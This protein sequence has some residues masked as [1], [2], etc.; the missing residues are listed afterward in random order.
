MKKGL[1]LMTFLVAFVL[2][3]ECSPIEALADDSHILTSEELTAAWALAGLDEN[4]APYHEGMEFSASMNASQMQ[5]WLDELLDNEVAAVKQIQ[6][7]MEN[8]LADMKREDPEQY[9]LLTQ[10]SN[11]GS[12]QAMMQTYRDAEALRQLLRYYSDK[13]DTKIGIIGQMK[14][15]LTTEGYTRSQQLSA[16]REIEDAVAAIREIRSE[17]AEN[18]GDWLRSVEEWNMAFQGTAANSANAKRSGNA[19]ALDGWIADVRA[20]QQPKEVRTSVSASVLYP[21][22]SKQSVMGRLNLV[23]S[24]LADSSQTVDVTVKN[25][26]DFNITLY[27]ANKNPLPNATATVSTVD[28]EF[29]SRTD[30][31]GSKGLV[32][33]KSN[34]FHPDSDKN[35]TLNVEVSCDGFTPYLGKG[36]IFEK[37]EEMKI[38]LDVDP[39]KPAIKSA[40]FNGDHKHFRDI[41]KNSYDTFFSSLND[42][43]FDFEVITTAPAWVRLDVTDANGKNIY[44]NA[45]TG[46][47][48]TV[49]F[50][51]TWKSCIKPGTKVTVTVSDNRA[52]TNGIK[53]ELML[54]VYQGVVSA[55]VQDFMGIFD[56]FSGGG[57]TIKAPSGIP[58]LSNMTLNVTIPWEDLLGKKFP[59]I[60]RML[61][62]LDG[63]Y[64]FYISGVGNPF[65]DVVD[66]WKSK[67][68]K[69]LNTAMHNIENQTITKIDMI[70]NMIYPSGAAKINVA[71]M[72]DCELTFGG[73]FCLVA[74]YKTDRGWK[75]DMDTYQANVRI[76][77]GVILTFSMQF[78]WYVIPTPLISLF[79]GIDLSVVVGLTLDILK[80]RSNGVTQSQVLSQTS[81][82]TVTL[83]LQ[84]TFGVNLD[85]GVCSVTL[86]GY[87]YIR[88]VINFPFSSNFNNISFAAYAGM[89]IFLEVHV[90]F[91]KF[92]ASYNFADTKKLKMVN[93][94]WEIYNSR[95]TLSRDSLPWF[96]GLLSI[97][98][99]AEEERETDELSKSRAVEDYSALVPQAQPVLEN[100]TIEGTDIRY[101]D[102]NGQ[103]YAF[104]ISAAQDGGKSRL[105]WV[106]MVTGKSGTFDDFLTGQDGEHYPSLSDYAFDVQ[107]VPLPKEWIDNADVSYKDG[108]NREFYQDKDMVAVSLLC[109]S[110]FHTETAE[111]DGK[112]Q[113][114]QAPNDS[115]A[116][117]F[118]CLHG[119]GDDSFIFVLPG[120]YTSAEKPQWTIYQMNTLDWTAR[121]TQLS[122]VP[123]DEAFTMSYPSGA[124][125]W[126]KNISGGLYISAL[127]DDA[128]SQDSIAEH[129]VIYDIQA[130]YYLQEFTILGQSYPAYNL[131][132][133]Q[134]DQSS[135]SLDAAA[136]GIQARQIGLHDKKSKD[137]MDA[138]SYKTYYLLTT[139]GAAAGNWRL[140]RRDNNTVHAVLDEGD[141]AFYDVLWDRNDRKKAEVFYL[142]REIQQRNKSD[143]DAEVATWHLKTVEETFGTRTQFGYPSLT[144]KRTNL[145]VTVPTDSFSL[146][147]L[148]ESVYIYWLELA[149]GDK[150][151]DQTTYRLRGVIFDPS[152]RVATDDF[153]LAQFTTANK[154]D[155]PVDMF[156]SADGMA[157]YTVKQ[158]GAARNGDTSQATVYAY[159]HGLKPHADLR[160][161]S[162]AESTVYAGTDVDAYVTISNDGSANINTIDLEVV[163][164]DEQGNVIQQGGKDVILETLHVNLLNP[165]ENS[166]KVLL[167]G[168]ASTTSGEGAIYRVEELPGESVQDRFNVEEVKTYWADYVEKND[169]YTVGDPVVTSLESKLLLPGQIAGFKTAVHI[170]ADWGGEVFLAV[171]LAKSQNNALGGYGE[172]KERMDQSEH[173]I[174]VTHRIYAGPQGEPYLHLTI[175]DHAENGEQLR[176]YAEMYLDDDHTPV[177]V[178]LPY[179]PE[180]TSTG[181]THNLDMPLSALLNG[182]RANV[183]NMTVRAVGADDRLASNNDITIYV[184]ASYRDTVRISLQPT[185]QTVLEGDTA[186][187]YVKAAGGREPY[188]YQWQE[189]MG[190]GLGWRNISE[191]TEDT[192]TV[193]D[194][195]LS[196]NGKQ[197]RCV[198]TDYGMEQVTSDSAV[199]NV[200]SALPPTGDHTNLPLYLSLAAAAL[201]LAAALRYAR[202]KREQRRE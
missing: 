25:K 4:A 33:F 148:N 116:Y 17:M 32:V 42:E 114:Y 107:A 128:P 166:R 139:D 153:V 140:V 164:E 55:P 14:N 186:L 36:L 39:G 80:E 122:L 48:C 123:Q 162:L 92:K 29:V 121:N 40:S 95:N 59:V 189:N 62:N 137:D 201:L 143:D 84:I 86:G 72:F 117:L 199:L 51:Y 85:F 185:D 111:T 37:G 57:F 6:S 144:L 135:S 63:S 126:K 12:Y 156:L 110:G 101:V 193:A 69:D 105:T 54:N 45:E 74:R 97:A 11:D 94:E 49:N 145:D 76:Q 178:D 43:S 27:D 96:A 5:K 147:Y 38:Y 171:R 132:F 113:E 169:Q 83:R 180:H 65:K 194:V 13:L 133:A 184:P 102:I 73:F 157:Y 20:W 2:L 151:A 21:G 7:E 104:Y 188:T 141:I 168:A 149:G 176:L 22:G 41:L 160:A 163:L 200:V 44:W 198:I 15:W 183:I 35:Y 158:G 79:V 106:N 98:Q 9:R 109:T 152:A 173:D 64:G 115:R 90:L 71:F 75:K 172:D 202:K 159:K 93:G 146:Q 155:T 82:V 28:G 88:I 58:V 87:A 196:M 103:A 47:D 89:G 154:E 181:M 30:T 130:Y 52:G 23:S 16:S 46:T 187:F 118:G 136:S 91:F 1:R 61:F 34:D 78:R 167:D 3:I 99:A 77:L 170:P 127:L 150:A 142:V 10:G 131:A 31:T 100:L 19:M 165:A 197:Y 177:Y 24:A 56:T 125:S 175:L 67:D 18:S 81:G 8:I 174:D 124:G 108:S 129:M 161:F 192:L 66:G 112:T 195:K 182:R 26:N 60:P 53:T 119:P 190:S 191:A 50:S 138:E 134:M 120:K 70:K 68:A 179:Y